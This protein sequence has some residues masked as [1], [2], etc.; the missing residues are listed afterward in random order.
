MIVEY[1]A[2]SGDGRLNF[3][4]RF[5]E[6][7]RDFESVG[8]ILARH[9]DHD[10]GLAVDRRRADGRG[11]RIRNA[12][13]VFQA[14]GDAIVVR[15]RCFAKDIGRLRLPLSFENNPLRVVLTTKPAPRTPVEARA[16]SRTLLIVSPNAARRSGNT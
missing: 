15:D 5:I 1:D 6:F 14:H 2:F 9:H 8:Q 12:R 7:L 13:D 10:A 3:G 4:E 16:A 11:G